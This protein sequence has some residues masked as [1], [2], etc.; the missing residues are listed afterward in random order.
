[1]SVSTRSLDLYFY[2]YFLATY[3]IT[4]TSGKEFRLGDQRNIHV[5]IHVYIT[6]F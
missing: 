5:L 4:L 6:P 1:M 2:F 3:G